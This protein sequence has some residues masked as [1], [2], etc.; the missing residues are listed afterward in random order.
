MA[1]I[2]LS[3]RRNGRWTIDNYEETLHSLRARTIDN[4]SGIYYFCL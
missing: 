1:V 2:P 4:E 3:N